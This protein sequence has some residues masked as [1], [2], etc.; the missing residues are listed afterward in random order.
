MREGQRRAPGLY[1][2]TVPTGGGKTVASLAFALAQAKSRGLKRVVYVIPYTSIIEQTAATFR[3][4]LGKTTYWST[5]PAWPSTWRKMS[6]HRGNRALHTGERNLGRARGRDH[7]GAVF[8]VAFLLQTLSVPQASQPCPKRHH[9]D[10]AQMLPL[11]YLRPCVWAIVQLARYYGVSAVLCTAT[12]PAL[13]PIIRAFAL[14]LSQE[15]LCPMAAADWD[16]FRRVTF[17]RAGRRTWAE[18]AGE[19]QA[20]EQALCVVNT[21]KA[22]RDV[23]EKLSG[24]GQLPSVH[25]DDPCP[26]PRGAGRGAPPVARGVAL[27][28]SSPPR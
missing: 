9:L 1:T 21:R 16:A 20:R 19:L 27:T 22:A 14:E 11:P 3:E 12:Q 6:F 10:E 25:A 18:L 7:G 2:L 28:A 17:R 13:G 23:F 26:S 4:I 5:I 15:E 8:R 24:R